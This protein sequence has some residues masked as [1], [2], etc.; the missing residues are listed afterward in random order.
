[1]CKQWRLQ[2]TRQWGQYIEWCEHVYRVVIAFKM[3]EW[4]EQWI[5]VKFCVKLEHL[6]METIQIV[7]KAAAM[8]NGGLA[9]LSWQCTRSCI[10]SL[11]ECFCKTSI[12]PGD[13]APILPRFGTLWLPAFSTTKITFDREEISDCR[14]ESGKYGAADDHRGNCVR[15]QGAY[16]EGDWGVIILCTIFLV[17]SSINVFFIYVAGFFLD[18]PPI[19]LFINTR[20][21]QNLVADLT[22]SKLSK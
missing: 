1:M 10:M 6:S 2:C 20:R 16:F 5:C 18:R 4:V 21:L 9:A 11:A 12:C 3:T 15:S 19:Y 17:S 13:S 7:Q 8:G 22:I 14:W